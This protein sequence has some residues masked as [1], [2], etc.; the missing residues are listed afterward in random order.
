MAGQ[1]V[2]KQNKNIIIIIILNM[3]III[4]T[5]TFIIII[6]IIMAFKQSRCGAL[7]P[8]APTNT[9]ASSHA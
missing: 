1:I 2:I 8:A 9:K 4:V 6:I 3:I 7:Q 5:I